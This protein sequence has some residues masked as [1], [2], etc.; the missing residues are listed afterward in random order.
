VH[1]EYDPFCVLHKQLAFS[2][3]FSVNPCADLGDLFCT[4]NTLSPELNPICH[5]LALLGAHHILHVSRIRVKHF[6]MLLLF[7]VL[8]NGGRPVFQTTRSSSWNNRIYSG[9]FCE[10]EI[11]LAEEQD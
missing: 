10:N 9:Y 2:T 3:F 4:F 6:S 5:L 7:R 1:K 11:L 8:P